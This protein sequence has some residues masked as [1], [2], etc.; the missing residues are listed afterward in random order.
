MDTT[1]TFRPREPLSA[2]V[3][4]DLV[5]MEERPATERTLANLPPSRTMAGL[6]PQT[7]CTA[8]DAIWK[9]SS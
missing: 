7:S 4:R 6:T 9:M 2:H 3:K 1:Q 5:S 8:R